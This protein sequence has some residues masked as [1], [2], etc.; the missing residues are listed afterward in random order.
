MD[1]AAISSLVVDPG[2]PNTL[3]AGVELGGVYRSTDG[4]AN[5]EPINQGIDL[6]HSSDWVS[7]VILNPGDRNQLWLADGNTMY[8]SLDGGE[9][10]IEHATE[11][12][13]FTNLVP[14]PLE[15]G[16][17]YATSSGES[18]AVHVS[19]DGGQTWTVL[20]SLEG[21]WISPNQLAIDPVIGEHLYVSGRDGPTYASSDGGATWRQV[22]DHPCVLAAD[23]NDESAAYCAWGATV[24]RTSDGGNTWRE[25]TVE[26][27]PSYVYVLMIT[28][29]DLGAYYAGT[30]DGLFVLTDL[31]LNWTEQSSGLP[32]AHLDLTMVSGSG[33]RLYASGDSSWV[34]SSGVNAFDWEALSAPGHASWAIQPDGQT[35][36]ATDGERLWQSS[37]AGSTWD[38]RS[39][40]PIGAG[41]LAVHPSLDGWV[42]S[43]YSRGQSAYLSTDGGQTWQL[44]PGMDSIYDA[45]LAFDPSGADRVYAIGDLELYRSDDAGRSWTACPWTGAFTSRASSRALINPHDGDRP[46]V[47][48][49]GQGVLAS[50]DGCQSWSPSN[51]GLETLF[52]NTLTRSPSD[53][54]TIYAATDAGAYISEDRGASW[55]PVAGWFDA[56]TIVYSLVVDPLNPGVLY[57]ATP[58][59]VFRWELAPTPLPL[60]ETAAT[61]TPSWV[62][63]FAEPILQAIEGITPVFED[64]FSTFD[65]GWV[66]WPQEGVDW[67]DGAMRFTVTEGS[68]GLGRQWGTADFVFQFDIVPRRLD[69]SDSLSVI[70][71]MGGPESVSFEA[72]TI[73]AAGGTSGGDQWD[74]S[75]DPE[76]AGEQRVLASG[77]LP[78]LRLSETTTVTVIAWQDEAAVYLNGQPVAYRDASTMRGDW[79]SFNLSSASGLSE[80]DFDNVRFWDITDYTAPPATQEAEAPPPTATAATDTPAWVTDF[81]EP[82]LEAV[83]DRTPVFEDDFSTFDETWGG[84]LE[85]VDWIDGA[86]RFT[87]T[88]GDLYLGRRWDTAHFVFQ[89]DIIPRR[90]DVSDEVGLFFRLGGL[91]GS[92]EGFQ[93]RPRGGTSGGDQWTWKRWGPPEEAIELESGELPILLLSEPT[94]V[95][96]IAWR[97]QAAVYLN[98]QPV[99]Y[100]DDSTMRGDWH[101]ITL[102]SGSGLT[103]VEFDNVRFWDITY[104]TIP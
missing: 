38:E 3:Y 19:Q 94:R 80:I 16:T 84:P 74:W 20:L 2:D 36:Y 7:L 11:G 26:G 60:A 93:I 31:G 81:A 68:L 24:L 55:A 41:R 21:E 83:E 49:R 90:L 35:A 34:A 18:P 88:E 39:V 65:A 86:M 40:P 25:I 13:Q 101:T 96:V 58:E 48:T 67:I 46:L 87:V 77:E 17:L 82:I 4:G 10:W 53:P 95:T 5:W 51:D 43:L 57:A 32:L 42:Y 6:E 14:H 15:P 50:F 92:W 85:G 102:N 47:A 12:L 61:T 71:R 37:D 99:A 78:I 104:L 89:F 56:D 22:L 29:E 98:G 23:P 73:N 66:P 76:G 1:R 91:E 69:A 72:F 64:D 44:T 100:R 103:E 27:P 28:S 70:F 54:D 33:P 62:A 9:I 8:E 75:R 45:R 79:L 63:D 30:S 59:G 97:D 52:V